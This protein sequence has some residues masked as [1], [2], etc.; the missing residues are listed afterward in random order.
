MYYSDSVGPKESEGA[1]NEGALLAPRGLAKSRLRQVRA[2]F[3]TSGELGPG[4][5]TVMLAEVRG[6]LVI[7][8]TVRRRIAC[9]GLLVGLGLFL[10]VDRATADP[11]EADRTTARALAAEGYEALERQD[12]ATAEDRLRRADALVHAPTIVV[13][14]A[15][16]LIGLGRF[17]EAYESYQLVMRE[18]LPRNAPPSWKQAVLEA[19]REVSKVEPRLAWLV[20]KVEG[21]S[22]P[23]VTI[24][25]VTIPNASLGVRR[26]IDPGRRTIRV[27]ADGFVSGGRSLSLKEA[28]Q[29]EITI[30]LDKPPAIQLD[31]SKVAPA[32]PETPTDSAPRSQIPMWTAF[33]VGAAGLTFGTITGILFLDKH[34]KLVDKCPNDNRCDPKDGAEKA[35]LISMRSS[36]RTMGTLSGIGFGLGVAGAATGVVMLLTNPKRS[37]APRTGF[38]LAPVVGPDRVGVTGR[39]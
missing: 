9:S 6:C 7:P 20:L 14:R 17:V 22:D 2:D 8:Y 26:P 37:E 3:A 30:A 18:T 10:A 33:G 16:A 38:M 35:E 5:C 23:R 13:D 39:F 25:G 1:V 24:D 15:K 12:Y 27:T 4:A 32:P 19:E 11:S 29:Q 36:Y 34:G 21:P 31:E 28:E